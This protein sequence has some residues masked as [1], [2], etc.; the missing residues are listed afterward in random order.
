MTAHTYRDGDVICEEHGTRLGDDELI[1]VILDSDD[2]T[3]AEFDAL[4]KEEQHEM[5]LD[6]VAPMPCRALGDR[7]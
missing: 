5:Q 3:R 6:W 2:M 4:P 7:S 1:S